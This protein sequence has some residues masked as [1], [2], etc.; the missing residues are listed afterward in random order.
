MMSMDSMKISRSNM[1]VSH[2]IVRPSDMAM[3]EDQK[4]YL[5]GLLE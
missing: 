5:R 4:L 2:G 1:D 3:Q